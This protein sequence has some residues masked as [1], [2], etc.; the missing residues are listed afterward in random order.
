MHL[1]NGVE[2][3]VH[4]DDVRAALGH[5]RPGDPHGQPNIRL[6]QRQG[7]TS[8]VTRQQ[9]QVSLPACERDAPR[10]KLAHHWF[11]PLSLPPPLPSGGASSPTGAYRWGRNEPS[12][13][14]IHPWMR[15]NRPYLP[16][17]FD[18]GFQPSLPH[19]LTITLPLLGRVC[20]TDTH[21]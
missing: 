19:L 8:A 16:H 14:P 7:P 11:H 1:D 20:M 12:P 4:D 2:V 10:V 13:A 18:P 9:C 3:V 6:H 21:A 15:V 17:H 5:L